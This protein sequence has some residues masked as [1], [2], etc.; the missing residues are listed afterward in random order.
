MKLAKGLISG[1]LVCC[2]CSI[3]FAG[4]PLPPS[5]LILDQSA[6]L[7]PWSSAII[8]AFQSSVSSNSARPISYF[9]EHLDIFDFY[10]P[11]YGNILQNYFGNKYAGRP[12]GVILSIGPDALDLAV[13]LRAAVW[14]AVP[15]VF[16]GVDEE[17]VPR[18]LPPN[19]TGIAIRRSFATMVRVAQMIVP[20][21]KRLALVGDRLDQQIYDRHFVDEISTFS[22][23]FE[24]I[25]LFG[26]PVRKV[27]QRVTTLSM[28]AAIF[29]FGINADEEAR[30]ASAVEVLPLIA[31]AANRPVIMDAETGI[32]RGSI[33]G[34]VRVPDQVGRDAGRLA[35]RLLNGDNASDIPITI[36]NYL[37][38]I[39]D[40][41]QLK[42]WGVADSRLPAE[43][44]IRFRDP[45]AWERYRW[46]IM[47]IA[48][49][50]LAQMSLIFALFLERRRRLRAE[51]RARQQLSELAHMNRSATAG[52]LTASIAH[53]V[54]QPLT[55][56]ATNGNA[57]L[58][59]LRKATPD[60]DQTGAALERIVNAA[61][62]ASD[63]VSTIRLMFKKGGQEM[64][65]LA[66]NTVI[67][68]VLDLLRTDFVRRRILV[69]THL[70]SGLP[71]ILGRRVQLQQV[72]LNLCI[73]AADAMSSVSDRDPVLKVMSERQ[74]SG[75]LIIIED[76]G[77]GVEPEHM[78]RIFEPF[79]TTKSHGMG[80]GLSI[81][82]SIIEEHGGRLFATLGRSRGLT[83]QISLPENTIRE[84]S[85]YEAEAAE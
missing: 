77:P 41:R 68:E 82:R 49:V 46:Q 52:E 29:Y 39:F 57:A 60:L 38:P 9:V 14:P 23:N 8:R 22:G 48:G 56:I 79:Y 51:A 69:Q 64:E 17:R 70:Q 40:W 81:C 66:I 21:L 30:Y 6:S 76:S 13:Q 43:S 27:R 35:I 42:R 7:R 20:N 71:P 32:G 34:L 10:S 31:E 28:D 84:A 33:G 18:Q 72:I 53:E 24:I 74:P 12:I 55:A 63:V 62:R 26:L 83:M 25:D 45:T 1:L 80:M 59:W 65:T 44:E 37:K 50:L 16:A 3:A 78:E 54:R 73:N 36:G 5:V 61:H 11:R 4:S 15:V 2:L 19:I 85:K 75:L 58:R 47:A 67:K